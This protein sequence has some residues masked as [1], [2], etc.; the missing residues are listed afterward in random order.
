LADGDHHSR[1]KERK[2]EGKTVGRKKKEADN[3]LSTKEPPGFADEPPSLKSPRDPLS[4][5][6]T[7]KP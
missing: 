4:Q 2:I 3:H 6:K 1:C 5:R 7:L